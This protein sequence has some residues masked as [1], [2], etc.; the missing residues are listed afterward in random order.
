MN[1][2]SKT[3]IHQQKPKQQAHTK[4]IL[5]LLQVPKTTSKIMAEWIL[6]IVAFAD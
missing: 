1:A 4:N 6:H 2:S 5:Q 3:S